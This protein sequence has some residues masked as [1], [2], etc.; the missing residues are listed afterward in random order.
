MDDEIDDSRVALGVASRSA[1]YTAAFF[2]AIAVFFQYFPNTPFLDWGE[3]ILKCTAV[4]LALVFVSQKIQEAR[5]IKNR[6]NIPFLSTFF[7]YGITLLLV[8]AGEMIYII[9]HLI[10]ADKVSIIEEFKFFL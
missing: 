8:Y 2:I 5:H 10:F 3:V 6:S 4:L 7:F 9:V 1:L